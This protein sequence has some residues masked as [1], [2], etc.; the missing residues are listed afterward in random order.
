[1]NTLDQGSTHVHQHRAHCYQRWG[2][3][4]GWGPSLPGLHW[5]FWSSQTEKL[6]GPAANCWIMLFLSL[7]LGV[8][9]QPSGGEPKASTYF[10][11]TWIVYTISKSED[12]LF[13]AIKINSPQGKVILN[14]CLIHCK[15]FTRLKKMILP[16]RKNLEFR[17]DIGL[18][19][20]QFEKIGLESS[21]AET[22]GKFCWWQMSG[23]QQWWGRRESNLYNS[24]IRPDELD[25]LMN[26]YSYRMS[27]PETGWPT[28]YP[29]HVP[30][31]L[32]PPPTVIPV[33]WQVAE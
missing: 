18:L 14:P 32:A 25:S 33:P 3:C 2:K 19:E 8:L 28:Q 4:L 21:L 22:V 29:S 17:S 24:Y 1:M 5:T 10:T 27:L 12:I 6:S 30:P 16:D 11:L 20:E 26:K 13:E 31:Q 7:C 9:S 15:A 23:F